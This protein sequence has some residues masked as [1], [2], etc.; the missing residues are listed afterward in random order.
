MKLKSPILLKLGTNVGFG[1]GVIKAEIL[2]QKL[3]FSSSSSPC[4][5]GDLTLLYAYAYLIS[6]FWLSNS[7]TRKAMLNEIKQDLLDLIT[8]LVK[9]NVF[10]STT[11]PM[12]CTFQNSPTTIINYKISR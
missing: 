7:T 8:A 12:Q 5:K 3:L 10:F 6:C 2:S 11:F 1:E 4:K 9:L